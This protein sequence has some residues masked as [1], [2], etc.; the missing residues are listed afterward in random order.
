MDPSVA[1][2]ANGLIKQYKEQTPKVEDLFMLGYKAG[3][4]VEVKGWINE[5]VTIK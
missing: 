5:T 1:E 3:D 2:T 4:K